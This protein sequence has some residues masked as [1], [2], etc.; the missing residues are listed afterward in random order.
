MHDEWSQTPPDVDRIAEMNIRFHAVINNASA[1]PPIDQLLVR[2]THLPILYRV[3]HVYTPAQTTTALNEHDT[4]VR[5]FEARDR[6]WV[7]SIV[8]AHILA[9]LPALLPS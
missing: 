8:R 5:A 6:D 1:S 4:I 3:F 7:E 2:A 9:A